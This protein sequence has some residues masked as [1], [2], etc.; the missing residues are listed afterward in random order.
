MRGEEVD[1]WDEPPFVPRQ[2][3]RSSTHN[4]DTPETAR[5]RTFSP[6][7]P[8]PLRSALPLTVL[9]QPGRRLF[10]TSPAET[11]SPMRIFIDFKTPRPVRLFFFF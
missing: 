1:V 6:P 11:P 3:H 7:P 9:H 8:P 5:L 2:G 10:G 4:V